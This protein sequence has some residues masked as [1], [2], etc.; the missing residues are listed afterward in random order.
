MFTL[1]ASQIVSQ[2]ERESFLLPPSSG[3]QSDSDACPERERLPSFTALR[4]R[5]AESVLAR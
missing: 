2:R 3:A 4:D 5:F 1:M